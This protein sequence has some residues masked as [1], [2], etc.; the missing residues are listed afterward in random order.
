VLHL[1]TAIKFASNL[2]P[3]SRL[4]F[5][6]GAGLMFSLGQN[7]RINVNLGEGDVIGM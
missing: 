3:A 7:V 6:G 5:M 2:D 1:I 4:M